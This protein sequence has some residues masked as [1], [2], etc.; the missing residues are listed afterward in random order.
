MRSGSASSRVDCLPE[1][2][3]PRGRRLLAVH[4]APSSASSCTASIRK[5]EHWRVNLTYAL[6]A[7]L[8]VPLLDSARCPTRRSTRSC[9]SG[10]FRS[11]A[12]FLLVGGVFGLPH[13]ETRLWGG[14]LVTLV[15]SFTGIIGSLPIGILLALGRRSKLP[16]VRTLA[17]VFIEFWRGVPL[18]TVLFFATY[19]LPLFLPADWRIDALLRVLIGVGAVCR[20][21]YGRGR[22]RRIAGDSARPVRRR[23]GARARAIGA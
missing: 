6:G 22:A 17:I 16:I 11:F 7:I 4:R 10:S 5:S 8:L 2:V 23:H 12:F 18:I 20:R 19:M 9:S 21:L 15:I 14:L 3:G 1:T 13:V